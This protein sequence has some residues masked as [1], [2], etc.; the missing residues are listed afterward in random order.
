MF[1]SVLLCSCSKGPD[2]VKPYG[3]ESTV[4]T[5]LQPFSK[6]KIGQKWKLYITADTGLPLQASVTYGN[7]LQSGIK[8]TYT[9]GELLI[10]DEN[11]FNWV[12]RLNVQPRC[13]LN[14]AKLERLQIEG[15]AEVICLDSL[16]ANQLDLHMNS[17]SPQDL[18]LHVG[19]LSGA[20]TNSGNIRFRGRANIFTF[21][22]ENGAWFNAGAL[23]CDDAYVFHYTDRDIYISPKNIFKPQTWGNGNIYYRDS[24]KFIFE[25]QSHGKGRILQY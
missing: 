14:V 18:K 16:D 24:P 17:V 8:F 6:L 5:R 19:I 9:D 20:A 23:D 15:A 21:S 12:R 10:R 3:T 22:C 2:F 25:P 11:H 13:T 1:L 4:S 7:N